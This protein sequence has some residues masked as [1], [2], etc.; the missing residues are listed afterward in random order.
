[1]PKKVSALAD[2]IC[3]A[4]CCSAQKIA[5]LL[6]FCVPSLIWE[7]C[8]FVPET[9]MLFFLTLEPIPLM[10]S[11][12]FG[13]GAE[14][15]VIRRGIQLLFSSRTFEYCFLRNGSPEIKVLIFGN[16]LGIFYVPHAILH[17]ISGQKK[18]N[19]IILWRFFPFPATF[20]SLQIWSEKH[21]TS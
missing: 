21:R 9:L 14:P 17:I 8:W 19:T 1:M 12:F 2:C 16:R 4:V 13:G 18:S 15:Q 7:M 11:T 5:H 20:S 6:L 3:L 10:W